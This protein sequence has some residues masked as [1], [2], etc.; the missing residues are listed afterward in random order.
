MIGL[1]FIGAIGIWLLVACF[2]GGK[3]PQWLKL[4][5]AWSWVFVPLVFFAPVL[6]EAVGR[7]QFARLCERESVVWLSPDWQSVKAVRDVPHPFTQ[8]EWTSIPIEIQ[9]VERIDAETGRPFMSYKAFH[10]SGGVLL[11]RLGFGL[12]N[13]TSCRPN[14]RDEISKTIDIDNL[15][16]KGKSK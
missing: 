15:L 11:G 7:W 4:K 2:L 9:H 10:T 14:N 6:D 16:E 1:L 3:L 5:Q 13:S 8:A 12:G